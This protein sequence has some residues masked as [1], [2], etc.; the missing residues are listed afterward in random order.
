MNILILGATGFI[1]NSVFHKLVSI[2]NITLASRQRLESYGNWKFVDFSK[3]NDWEYVLK[4]IDLVINAIGIIEGDFE[5]IQTKTPLSLFST[6]VKKHIKIINIS[7]I[8]AEKDVPPTEF[9]KSKKIVDDFLLKQEQTI[10]IYPGIVIGQ[11]GKSTQFFTELAHLPI[12]PVLKCSLP[13]IHIEQLTTL[14][15]DTV[16]NFNNYPK[17]VFALSEPESLEDL[18]SA[19]KGHKGLFIPISNFLLTFLFRIFPK[20]SIGIF[21]REMLK[22]IQTISTHDYKPMFEKTSS[23]INPNDLKAGTTFLDLFALLTVIYVWVWSGISSL[24]SW[25]QSYSLMKEIGANYN[26]SVIFIL[27]GSFVDIV[28][29]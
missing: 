13:S 8:G 15:Q 11:N 17:Q 12:I 4:D 28:L 21:N 7:A 2:H 9:L 14:L 18:L 27:L 1:G 26:T 23:K 24:I 29:T 19:I 22:M 10:V 25:E 3:E 6:C 5:R 20:I 16:E